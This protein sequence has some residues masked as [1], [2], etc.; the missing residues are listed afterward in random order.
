MTFEKDSVRGKVSAKLFHQDYY[1]MHS[2]VE[3]GRYGTFCTLM[4]ILLP[5]VT[6]PSL[7]L[8]LCCCQLRW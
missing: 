6:Y 1:D 3:K 5:C 4:A 8:F 2:S 7:T